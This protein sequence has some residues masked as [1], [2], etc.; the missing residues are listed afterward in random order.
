MSQSFKSI[1]H[2]LC[3]LLEQVECWSGHRTGLLVLVIN[4]LNVQI[5]VL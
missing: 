2:S 3:E 4:Q 5:L 1:N